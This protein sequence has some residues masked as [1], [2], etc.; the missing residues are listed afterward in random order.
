MTG[1]EIRS[2]ILCGGSGTRLWPL[3][4]SGFP[5]QFLGLTAQESLLQQTVM[6]VTGPQFAPPIV[7]GGAEHRFMIA[8]H[9]HRIGVQPKQII[10][11]P[12]PRNTAAAVALA[13]LLAAEDDPDTLLLI[14]PSDHVI[15]DADAFRD[16]VRTAV[17]AAEAGYIVTFG[18]EPTGPSVAY[19][20]VVR[21][22]RLAAAP[23]GFLVER[24]VEK[25]DR[26]RAEGL[27]AAGGCSWNGGIFLF[28]AGT[29]L[30]EL[31]LHEPAILA[32]CRESLAG[33]KMDLG[34]LRPDA[35][36][37]A[38]SPNISI[39]YAVMEKTRKAAVVPV[40]ALG[41]SDVGSF[42]AL[43]DIGRKD[44]R[45]NVI[46][47]DVVV[48]DA[49][50]CLIHAEKMVAALGVEDLVIIQTDD[51]LFVSTRDRSQDVKQMVER[52]ADIGRPEAKLHS[53]VHRPWGTYCTVAAGDRYQVKRITVKPACKL[54][55]QFHHHRA[56]HWVVVRG[57]ARVTCG[58]Q[59]KLLHEN[60][61][62][63]IPLGEVHRLENP[64][65]LDLELI[66][67][68][69]GPYLGEDDIVRVDD[70]Y[71]RAATERVSALDPV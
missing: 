19:G 16:G 48:Q 38:A 11:E 21:G 52:L 20:Y 50:N 3:S 68:Q 26:V 13:A 64:G 66:E 32:A 18:I 10:L 65:V 14:L 47:G 37:F 39:D 22:E 6:R 29:Y 35:E 33:A 23:G 46:H 25:P 15:R 63:Y 56:E 49:E 41:W 5:K 27:I 31:E 8:D 4:R 9:L 44:N 36:R 43:Y 1:S 58:T 57:T 34:F 17:A 51:V 54:S 69:S 40:N 55:M 42:A 24:F 61:S 70:A 67:V 62:T 28:K 60:Q 71:G 30:S 7:V 59:V 12:V 2:V 45:G 53:T